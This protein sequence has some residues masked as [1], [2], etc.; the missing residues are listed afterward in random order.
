MAEAISQ[1]DLHDRRRKCSSRRVSNRFHASK[2]AHTTT[3]D[4]V[5]FGSLETWMLPGR[6]SVEVH[7]EKRG[8]N[9]NSIDQFWWLAMV[10]VWQST[11][12]TSIAHLLNIGI[13]RWPIKAQPNAM[14]CP[15]CIQVCPD[16]ISMKRHEDYIVELTRNYLEAR[17]WIAPHDQFTQIDHI[18]LNQEKWFA[19]SATVIVVDLW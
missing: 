17:V 5:D 9:G 16:R 6:V 2:S 8:F 11:A 3:P 4:K 1:L 10:G 18:V 13:H 12:G 14:Q 7:H 15:I 19:K